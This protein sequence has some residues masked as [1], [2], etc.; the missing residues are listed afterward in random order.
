[1]KRKIRK[2]RVRS[3]TELGIAQLAKW[4]NPILNGWLAYYG[5]FYRS[6]LYA[7]CWHVNKALVRWARRKFKPLR[8][9]KTRAVKFM[10]GISEQCPHLFAHWRQGMRGSF[11]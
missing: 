8:Q 1:M 6:A 9:H 2:L 7:I 3:R 5:A 10:E 11:A 4:L